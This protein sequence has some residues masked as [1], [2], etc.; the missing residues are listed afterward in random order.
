MSANVTFEVVDPPVRHDYASS[1][2]MVT[3]EK[4]LWKGT[5]AYSISRNK[6]GKRNSDGTLFYVYLHWKVFGGFGLIGYF[7]TIEQARDAATKS[8]T[9]FEHFLRTMWFLPKTLKVQN[10]NEKETAAKS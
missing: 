3:V 2:C 10:G 4:V 8:L 9:E 5:W 7:E 6:D 1:D